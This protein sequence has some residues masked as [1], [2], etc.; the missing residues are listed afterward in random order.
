MS[1]SYLYTLQLSRL[2][3]ALCAYRALNAS[4]P[5]NLTANNLE[6]VWVIPEYVHHVK[7]YPVLF[8]KDMLTLTVCLLQEMR[9]NKVQTTGQQARVENSLWK[10]TQM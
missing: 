8:V 2:T 7:M 6:E 3:N 5:C 1:K 4:W 10:E 9:M